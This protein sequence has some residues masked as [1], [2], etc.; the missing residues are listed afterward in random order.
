MLSATYRIIHKSADNAE[1]F[2]KKGTRGVVG[3]FKNKIG[4]IGVLYRH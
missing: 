4:V 3:Y 1:D 2:G